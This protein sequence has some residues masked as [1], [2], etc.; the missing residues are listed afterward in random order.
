MYAALAPAPG[1]RPLPHEIAEAL[2]P[3]LER[4]PVGHLAG[5]RLRA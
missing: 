2:Q 3:V 5:F 4:Q 1:D